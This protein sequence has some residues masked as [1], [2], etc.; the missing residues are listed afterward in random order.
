MPDTIGFSDDELIELSFLRDLETDQLIEEK[1]LSEDMRL[2]SPLDDELM[3]K[4]GELSLR[5]TAGPA[6]P[7]LTVAFEADNHALPRESIIELRARLEGIVEDAESTNNLIKWHERNSEDSSGIYEPAMVVLE[8]AKE[9][10]KHLDAFRTRAR[11]GSP[12]SDSELPFQM[13]QAELNFASGG[14]ALQYL[15]KTAQQISDGIPHPFRVLHIE[16]VLRSDLARAFDRR[17][18]KLR[19]MLATKS[20]A[21]LRHH[22]PPQLRHGNRKED[23]VDYLV[24]PIMTFHGTQRQYVPS[25]VRHGFL[26]PGGKNPSTKIEHEVRCGSTYVSTTNKLCGHFIQGGVEVSGSGLANRL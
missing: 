20:L 5:I 4:H 16:E 6:Y 19:A 7:V 23:F 15:K 12:S 9:T 8:L 3:L 18:E 14:M 21:S 17:Q 10:R 1:L 26:K 2:S 22:I 13:K 24:K 11:A 25:I